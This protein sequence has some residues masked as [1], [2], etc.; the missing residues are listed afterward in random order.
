MVNNYDIKKRILDKI[1]E[2]QRIIIT[3]HFRPDGDAVGSTKGLQNILKNSYPDKEILLI[4]DDYSDYL[5]FLGGEDEQMDDAQYRNALIIVLDTASTDRISN[6]KFNLGAEIIKIDHHID[7]SPYG[8]IS[9]VED[10]RSSL[11]EQIVDF[12]LTFKDRLVLT[13]EAATYIYT[14]MVTDTGRFKFNSVNEHTMICAATLLEKGIDTDWLFANLY[15]DDFNELKFQS[16][17]YE[18]M[19]ITD[20]GVAYLV[21]DREMKD[22]FDLTQEQASQ[23]VSYLDSIKGSICWIA[24]IENND[25]TYRVRLRSRFM[26]INKVAEKYRGGGHE[27]ACGATLLDPREIDLLL[28]DADMATKEY[29][30]THEGWM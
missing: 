11:C 28:Y 8:D 14:G 17:C 25:G 1:E 24:F 10:W 27:C 9:W 19:L 4:N 29:K 15:L 20:N 26:T 16:Y 22:K 13:K 21:V 23:C 2:Y 7:I 12:Y 5:A 30:S 3:R 6:K 18:K